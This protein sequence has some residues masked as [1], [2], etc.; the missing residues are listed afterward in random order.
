[1]HNA[2]ER[3]DKSVDDS[4][5][6]REREREDIKRCESVIQVSGGKMSVSAFL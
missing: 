6:E 1:M 5:R 2:K 4:M 3:V